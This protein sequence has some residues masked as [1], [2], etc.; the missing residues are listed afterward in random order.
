MSADPPPNSVAVR[1]AP[2]SLAPG[3]L[4]E[5]LRRLYHL[6]A[7]GGEWRVY[8]HDRS[9][10]PLFVDRGRRLVA[11][12]SDPDV[13]REMTAIA[14]HRGWRLLEA[15]GA[16]EFRREAWIAG[17]AAGLVVRGHRPTSRDLQELERRLEASDREARPSP[18]TP[19]ERVEAAAADRMQVVE[20]LARAR[21][22]DPDARTGVVARAQARV[23]AWLDRGAQFPPLGAVR[24]PA[25]EPVPDRDRPRDR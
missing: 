22:R 9:G 12:R 16:P 11:D 5:R 24:A 18:P 19:R 17:Q 7:R 23:E 4:P 15:S 10:S 2:R 3:D 25:P 14:L 1:G 21:I 8:R 20:A 13:V 6:E